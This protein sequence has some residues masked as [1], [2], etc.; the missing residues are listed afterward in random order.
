MVRCITCEGLIQ[1]L[2]EA[3]ETNDLELARIAH[4]Q[5]R[6]HLNRVKFPRKHGFKG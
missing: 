3:K 1:K 4:E 6:E 5:M 2:K